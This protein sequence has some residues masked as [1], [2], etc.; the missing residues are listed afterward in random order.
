M[1]KK[2]LCFALCAVLFALCFSADAQQTKK[3]PQLG[4]LGGAT[5]LVIPSEAKLLIPLRRQFS[6]R[7]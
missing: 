6:R 7:R 3:V 4:Y 1:I 2:V 5:P